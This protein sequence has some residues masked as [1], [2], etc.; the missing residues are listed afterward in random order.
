V[1]K[2]VP[3]VWGR[4]GPYGTD[5]RVPRLCFDVQKNLKEVSQ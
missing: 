4:K 1:R 5:R 3:G 2:T